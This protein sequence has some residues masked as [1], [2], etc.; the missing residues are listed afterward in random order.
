MLVLP[1]PTQWTQHHSFACYCRLKKDLNVYKK[2]SR[3]LGKFAFKI[4][5]LKIFPAQNMDH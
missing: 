3:H 5:L 1:P 4:F 2:P